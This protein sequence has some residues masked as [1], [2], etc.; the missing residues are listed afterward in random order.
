M[1]QGVRADLL[2]GPLPD[3]GQCP[4]KV[5]AHHARPGLLYQ[6]NHCGVYRSESVGENWQDITEGL[7]SQFGFVLGLHSQDPDTLFVLP[8]DRVL[9]Q[10]M[11]GRSVL[12]HRSQVS[13]LPQPERRPEVGA[14]DAG[15]APR[16]CLPVC[17]Q[18][19]NGHRKPGP[20][21]HLRWHDNRAALS[22]PEQRRQL[23]II[24]GRPAVYL[25]DRMWGSPVTCWLMSKEWEYAG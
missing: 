3:F 9:G 5:L 20:L 13:G 12:C 17:P 2:P 10:D 7:P 21:R 25:V 16:E 6:Q 15:I 19:R 11:V 24:D 18:R 4:H 8:E 1:N 22:Q 14:A 23:G